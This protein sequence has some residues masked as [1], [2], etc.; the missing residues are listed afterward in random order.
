MAACL[1]VGLPAGPIE[2]SSQPPLT[3]PGPSV[4]SLT[5]TTLGPDAIPVPVDVSCTKDR[6]GAPSNLQ[7][8]APVLTNSQ[9][10]SIVYMGAPPDC[11]VNEIAAA[12][13][14]LFYAAAL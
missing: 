10:N 14:T 5:I 1:L 8:V 13:T 2:K 7:Q 12:R 3:Q 11:I 4:Q 6:V 9:K